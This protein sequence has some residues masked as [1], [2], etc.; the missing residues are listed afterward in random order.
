ML[1][2][3]VVPAELADVDLLEL[4][5]ALEQLGKLDPRQARV[6]QLRFLGGLNVDE[7]AEVLG[8]SKRTVEGDWTHAKAWLRA[9][10][11]KPEDE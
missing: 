1:D 11:N 6:V 4:H 5:D 7:V 8:V 9:E 10:L 3:A 2:Q